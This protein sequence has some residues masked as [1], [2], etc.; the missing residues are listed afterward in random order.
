MRLLKYAILFLVL[1]T[2]TAI[3]DRPVHAGDQIGNVEQ[4]S[5]ECS[6]T[7]DSQTSGATVNQ[8]ILLNDIISTRGKAQITIRF[9]D[10]TRLMLGE[11]SRTSI[12]S[13][14]YG[15]SDSNLLFNFSTGTFRAI[16]GKLVEVNPEGF[17]MKTPMTTLGI[18]GSDVYALVG[19]VEEEVGALDLGPN[20]TLEIKTSKQTVHIT[21]G[22]L[23][24]KISFSGVISTP[25]PIP[26]NTI[27]NM[28]ALGTASPQ[29]H[30]TGGKHSVI[31]QV[32]STP[33]VPVA[34]PSSSHPAPRRPNFHR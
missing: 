25:S 27:T 6:I 30:R 17:N 9:R 19:I 22:G 20:H 4:V 31:P 5:G 13:Y 16:T 11:S 7:R 14:I 29:S 24:S 33:R 3:E 15:G 34:P 1:I 26:P 10:G 2:F 28:K 32:P 12:D 23:Q 8:G 18:R 21:K